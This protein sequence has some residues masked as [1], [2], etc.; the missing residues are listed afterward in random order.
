M[1]LSERDQCEQ[2][3]VTR[4]RHSGFCL[5]SLVKISD[6][7]KKTDVSV[8]IQLPSSMHKTV[9]HPRA[10]LSTKH[11]KTAGKKRRGK[12]AGDGGKIIMQVHL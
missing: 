4:L 3:C 10:S 12:G 11:L 6:F 8:A 2:F 9:K 5:V 1:K 7:L